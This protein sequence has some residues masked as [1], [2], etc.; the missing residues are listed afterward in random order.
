MRILILSQ[1]CWPEVDHKC[2]PLAIEIKKA[3]HEVEILSG[4]PNRPNGKIYPGYKMSL[5]FRE[6][7]SGIRIIRVPSYLDH[8]QSGIKRMISYI[9]FAISASF[10]GQFLIKKPDVVF[11]YHA[12]A[13]IAVPAIYFKLIF[14]C[15]VF[16]DINDYWPDTIEELGMLK[17][18]MLLKILK[19]YCTNTYSFFDNIN[20]V[21]KGYKNKLL[22]LGVPETKISLIYNWSLPIDNVKSNYFD[23]Y[24]NDFNN[25]FIVLYAGNIGQAQSL[26][27]LLDV[28]SMF[29][30]DMISDIKI[31]ILGSGVEK[32][33]LEKEVNDRLLSDYIIFTGFIPSNNVGQFLETADVLLLHL[34]RIPLFDITI[35]SKLVS[36]FI[37]KKPVLCGVGGESAEIVN[38]FGA[39][40]SFESENV[41]D[42]Y[43]K[44]IL[45]KS[46][47]KNKMQKMGEAGRF[48]YDEYF[49]FE[50]GSKSIIDEL[51]RLKH[52]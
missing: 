32:E 21:S 33:Q 24:E 36:Y 25:N 41:T 1:Y 11:A 12:P 17:N 45:M 7:A 38:N 49:S 31:Y 8:S 6:T 39:G 20:V 26:S 9:T 2:L 34:K 27:I 28:A 44:I 13:T 46:F 23:K 16:Y 14:R 51:C 40:L 3:G 5:F 43:K 50:K 19:F 10:I 35:P 18:K 47:D 29:K 4:F 15:K 52:I 42:L 37:S 48:V 30:N 22:E